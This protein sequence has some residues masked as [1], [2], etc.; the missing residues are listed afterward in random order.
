MAS[1]PKQE[2]GGNVLSPEYM[3][4]L[5]SL[6]RLTRP[7]V[8]EVTGIFNSEFRR[9]LG[10]GKAKPS[11]RSEA[12]S[13]SRGGPST[14]RGGPSRGSKKRGGKSA[15]RGRGK[16]RGRKGAKG[17]DPDD[18]DGDGG[19]DGGNGGVDDDSYQRSCTWEPDQKPCWIMAELDPWNRMLA[20]GFFELREHKWGE[21]TLQGYAW[22]DTSA[23]TLPEVLRVSLLMHL[24]LRQHR[25]VLRVVWDAAINRVEPMVFWNAIETRA[26]EL[27]HFELHSDDAHMLGQVPPAIAT[28]WSRSLAALTSLRKLHLMRVFFDREVALT[29]GRY[30]ED[31]TSLI[32]LTV[33]EVSVENDDA[34][35]FLDYLARNC[36]LKSLWL[37]R[38]LLVARAGDALA[39]VVR[40][41][42]TLE[43]LEV[44]G[45]GTANPSALLKA[46]VQS[47]SLRTLTV[48]ACFIAAPD[49]RA[50]AAALTRRP[51]SPATLRGATAAPPSPTSRLEHLS[52]ANCPKTDLPLQRAY[53]NLI[54][55]VL[56]S[57]ALTNCNL[58]DV[59]AS[60]AAEKLVIDTR[61][62]A[63]YL[64]ENPFSINGR[65]T[66]LQ[67]LGVNT[68][69]DTF[70]VNLVCPANLTPVFDTIRELDLSSRLVLGWVNPDG[71]VFA[72]GNHLCRAASTYFD[73]DRRDPEDAR[74]L[75]DTLVSS[76]QVNALTLD[77][78]EFTIPSVIRYLPEAL[79]K[80]KYLRELKLDVA[81]SEA[82]AVSILRSLEDNRS[83]KRL[84]LSNMTFRRRAVKALGRMVEQNRTM[85]L[86][87]IDLMDSGVDNWTQLRSVCRELKEAILRNRFL[88]VVSVAVGD[89][90]RASDYVIKESL[91]RNMML[92]NQAIRF[93]YG[94]MQKS[95]ALAFETLQYS[96]SV[97]LMLC[98]NFS[99]TDKEAKEKVED[100]RKR[101]AA[102][103]FI[104]TGVIRR[105]VTCDQLGRTT[106]D[107]L[108]V[109]L[110]ALICSYLSLTDVMDV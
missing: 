81:V 78:T 45:G 76:R 97:P 71:D 2:E 14:S 33:D 25:C 103:Y 57:L 89:D 28:L 99:L 93:V 88:V 84:F 1:A 79:G 62:Q 65:C 98:E 74:I 16:G 101:L 35:T 94:S 68:T 6:C 5:Q 34:A 75:L 50:M 4:L 46:A 19:D 23:P 86:L 70:A 10:G 48:N 13:A 41:H 43:T 3:A 47:V 53:A 104:L 51:P 52:F 17:K 9:A 95:D 77:C 106:L 26:W 60:A 100:A 58:S 42:P 18:D 20:K 32:H 66:M 21:L 83:V 56:L 102:N 59:F 24:L 12:P 54:G 108:D 30:M 92:V 55:G 87:Y 27:E 61:L 29:L 11:K 44:S 40:K 85:N 73:L 72:E 96:Y 90:N 31:T 82:N 63:L 64:Q 107:D 80:T 15:P 37:Q 36:S 7:T 67:A 110:L 22:P 91:R 38:P 109:D 49:I 39:D 8:N 69:L 105:R